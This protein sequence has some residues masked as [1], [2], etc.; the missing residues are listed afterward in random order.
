M[1]AARK[2]KAGK[3]ERT[4]YHR[5][6]ASEQR[7]GTVLS[8]EHRERISEGLRGNQNR[9]GVPHDEETRR[10]I[11]ES[12]CS[13]RR[14]NGGHANPSS[15]EER[16]AI[17]LHGLGTT[18]KRQFR[19]LG[20]QV[21]FLVPAHKLVIET[22]GCFFHGC[23]ECGYED[24]PYFDADREEHRRAVILG[25]GFKMIE[26]WEHEDLF[27]RLLLIVRGLK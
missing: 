4:D 9:L 5:E 16:A 20:F 1:S 15:F 19:I 6:L 18:F 21:D 3:Y 13:Y 17:I 11:S 25:R 23:E 22:N 26:I 14:D 7:S 27:L 2:G 24:S 12:M 8:D 10:R